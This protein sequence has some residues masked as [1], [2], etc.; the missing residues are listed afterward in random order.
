MNNIISDV[1]LST[2]IYHK[3]QFVFLHDAILE[4][5]NVGNKANPCSTLAEEF[6]EICEEHENEES[7]L[8]KQFMVNID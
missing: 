2:I 7:E 1:K 4:A 3:D 6:I 8:Q 5:I